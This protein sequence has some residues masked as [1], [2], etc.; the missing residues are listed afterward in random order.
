VL[1]LRS[2]IPLNFGQLALVFLQRT[3][4]SLPVLALIAHGLY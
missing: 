4:I 1:V 2:S 3:L